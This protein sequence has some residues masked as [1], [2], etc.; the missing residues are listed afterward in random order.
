MTDEGNIRDQLQNEL[1]E[2][3][4]ENAR[5]RR[6]AEESWPDNAALR[7][8]QFSMD[9]ASISVFWI[10][11]DGRITFVNDMACRKLGYSADELIGMTVADMDPDHGAEIRSSRWQ[12]LKQSKT[13]TFES[14]H[15]AKDGRVF[16]VQITNHYLEFEGQEYEFGFA[17]DISDQKQAEKALRQSEEKYR[18]LAENIQ[19]VIWSLD[20]AT[21]K[22]T[23]ISPS[24]EKKSGYTVQELLDLPLAGRM[25]PESFQAVLKLFHEEMALEATGRADP[26]RT[27]TLELLEYAKDGHPVWVETTMSFAR[28]Q[29]GRPIGVVG[30][31]RDITEKKRFEEER[32]RLIVELEEALAKVK[33]LK[34]LVPICTSC[35]KIRDDQGFW[36]QVEIYVRD[37]SEAEFSHSICPDC[38]AKL[39]PEYTKDK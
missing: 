21:L 27:R 5:L 10:T 25:S 16:P 3:R 23:Y 18:L 1:K 12:M 8:T 13:M 37:H 11:P 24:V 30:V 15:R 35:K 4:R 29:A 14:R 38:L 22:L 19:E 32:E 20:L 6:A 33:T 31:S 9:N 28:D 34:G 17:L 36:H 39:Y 26:D 2:L 7:L